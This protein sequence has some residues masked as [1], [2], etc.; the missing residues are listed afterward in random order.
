LAVYRIIFLFLLCFLVTFPAHEVHASCETIPSIYT[1][2]DNV[3]VYSIYNSSPS[4]SEL[5][6]AGQIVKGFFME[7][8]SPSGLE[9]D[10]SCCYEPR[11]HHV[12]AA[13]PECWVLETEDQ[14][15][16]C[17]EAHPDRILFVDRLHVCNPF[18]D[19]F[20]ACYSLTQR[21][22]LIAL[23]HPD[24][25]MTVLSNLLAFGT[26]YINGYPLDFNPRGI[27]NP[28]S[29]YYDYITQDQCQWF[30]NDS[31]NIE[32]GSCACTPDCPVP[33][34]RE[35]PLGLNG[36][37][38]DEIWT[39]CENGLCAGPILDP[40]AD[41]EG[42]DDLDGVCTVND[43]CPD[44][45]NGLEKGTCNVEF[46]DF[47]EGPY[48]QECNSDIDCS[49]GYECQRNQED[50]DETNDIPDP[51][52]FGDVCDNC[53][54]YYN[55]SQKDNDYDGVGNKCDLCLNIENGPVYGTCV[56]KKDLFQ[57]GDPCLIDA[58]C[59]E[60]QFCS[61]AQDDRDNDLI[62]DV[63]D[64]C[65]YLNKP[66]IDK[67]IDSDGDYVGD[68]CDNCPTIPNWANAHPTDCNLD[69]IINA[70][71]EEVGRQCDQD[72][73][74]IGDVCDVCP[75]DRKNDRDNDGICA[76][77][78]FQF[79]KTGDKDN[80]P[81]MYNPRQ[82]DWDGIPPGNACDPEYLLDPNSTDPTFADPDGDNLSDA[83]EF[84]YGTDPY[85]ADSDYDNQKD[86]YEILVLFTSPIVSDTDSDGYFDGDDNCPTVFSENQNDSDRDNTGDVCDL[87]PADQK[88]DQDLDGYCKGNGYLPPK[89]G[90]RDNCP[91]VH[92]LNQFDWDRFPPGNACDPEYLLD[93]NST[94]PR[95]AD[96]DGDNLSDAIELEIGTD[97]LFNDTDH[98]THLDGYEHIVAFTN[99]LDSDSFPV[100][101]SISG[102]VIDT[103][104]N[105]V[106]NVLIKLG[107]LGRYPN[108][109][110]TL[111][112]T[113]E[114]GN[115]IFTNLDTTSRMLRRIQ[116]CQIWDS[117][118]NT[119][120]RI[121]ARKRRW[122]IKVAATY[123]RSLTMYFNPKTLSSVS[124]LEFIGQSR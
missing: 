28:N 82:D 31:D 32:P 24:F 15:D 96:P 25:N 23:N 68:A 93:P 12:A 99:P 56:F 41:A 20:P 61:R 58:D 19:D 114:D 118:K 14:L 73:D 54:T 48:M 50:L 72:W 77:I 55:P 46:L 109:R 120:I 49:G 98:D 66:G 13:S 113:D 105:A 22:I 106:P 75:A 33:V 88:N 123:E 67:N 116:A 47:L 62:G 2:I 60:N 42:D 34:I 97:P 17:M 85:L 44:V 117:C 38:C 26:G 90:D 59:D 18:S 92:N 6:T 122:H 115:F 74:L 52:G 80:C 51:D 30:I 71:S 84:Y 103:Y 91:S 112:Y 63:C 21:N 36:I 35:D 121:S 11:Y 69:G 40:C 78:G 79:P 3:P 102:R 43:N 16:N 83:E 89:L 57:Y 81:E 37:I 124:E 110:R 5:N 4:Q 95:F 104:G 94:D 108:R 70:S 1:Y 86:G 10:T 29:G 53:P 27:M 100:S 7:D 101:F 9:G 119:R 107:G 76:G 45:P 111:Q 65:I 64:L 39:T 8:K 87:C